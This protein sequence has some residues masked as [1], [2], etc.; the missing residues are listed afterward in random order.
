M[1]AGG[2]KLRGQRIIGQVHHRSKHRH[3]RLAFLGPEDQLFGQNAL[4]LLDELIRASGENGAQMLIA[5]VDEESAALDLLRRSG[6][7]ICARQRIWK[8][9]PEHHFPPATPSPWR[10]AAPEDLPAMQSLYTNLVPPMVQQIEPNPFTNGQFWVH[11]NGPEL[12]AI[13][14]VIRGPLGVRLQPYFHPAVRQIEE[15]LL[16]VIQHYLPL[17]KRPMFVCV[18]SYQGG[19][20][21]PLEKL[22]FTPWNDQAVMVR[23]LTVS[24]TQR[25]LA[26]LPSLEGQAEVSAPISRYKTQV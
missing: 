24:V 15:L 11:W 6:F 17:S 25:A 20:A 2:G 21:A 16:Q 8:V 13:L 7:A 10:T 23:R 26:P 3:A 1:I 12:L 19:F 5:D 22:G 4:A 9:S 14:E 18:R